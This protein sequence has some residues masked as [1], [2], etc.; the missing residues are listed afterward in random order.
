MPY[1]KD[2]QTM[3]FRQWQE[4]FEES[5]KMRG[6]RGSPRGSIG[7]DDDENNLG[8]DDG[9]IPFGIGRQASN[10][11]SVGSDP[12]M[13]GEGSLPVSSAMGLFRVHTRDLTG[14]R[15]SS[16]PGAGGNDDRAAG[17]R[18]GSTRGLGVRGRGL[19][20]GGSIGSESLSPPQLTASPTRRESRESREGREGREGRSPPTSST[21]SMSPGRTSGGKGATAGA[22]AGAAGAVGAG[23]G[24]T[25]GAWV[26]PSVRRRMEAE[27]AKKKAEEAGESSSTGVGGAGA[28]TA[29]V[30]AGGSAAPPAAAS[31][32]PGS[33]CWRRPSTRRRRRGT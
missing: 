27:A 31:G 5:Q 13:A 1:D 21:S 12:I 19:S 15:P 18:P 3:Q 30:S 25:G 2:E 4:E 22:T 33:G 10:T 9:G 17:G 23:G 29:A 20:H 6:Q 14:R 32:S 28:G 16:G 26:P 11:S 8:S 7:S 24:S